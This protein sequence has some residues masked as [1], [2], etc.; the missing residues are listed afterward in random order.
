MWY[1]EN[2]DISKN[3]PK[4]KNAY[5]LTRNIY[6]FILYKTLLKQLFYSFFEKKFALYLFD[7]V[8]I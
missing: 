2:D 4:E 7:T 1:L 5:L 3:L 8:E 6:V